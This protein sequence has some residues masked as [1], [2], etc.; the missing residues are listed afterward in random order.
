MANT[1]LSS[2]IV[3]ARRSFRLS[4]L[5]LATLFLLQLYAFPRFHLRRPSLLQLL[6]HNIKRQQPSSLR[7]HEPT[8]PTSSHFH[9]S[10]IMQCLT[11]LRSTLSA[12][13]WR[14][15]YRLGGSDG[16]LRTELR[17]HDSFQTV[18]T[19]RM[20]F[21]VRVC[22]SLMVLCSKRDHVL[23]Y[24]SQNSNNSSKPLLQLNHRDRTYQTNIAPS[25]N[26]IHFT[27]TMVLSSSKG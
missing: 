21:C 19:M 10:E 7:P 3:L 18:F 6:H 1:A 11:T 4:R 16:E 20:L 5:F 26:S 22:V 14:T 9:A 12:L 13:R 27:S 8:L 15:S 24:T 23:R 17:D 25:S 2:P